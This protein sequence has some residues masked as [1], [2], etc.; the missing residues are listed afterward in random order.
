M[1]QCPKCMREFKNDN[2]DHFCSEKPKTIEEYILA[3]PENVQPILFEVR[4]TLRGA[5]PD[6]EERI[7]W[8]MPTFWKKQNIIHFAAFKNHMGLY[9]GPDAIVHFA[10]CL[11]DY[12]SSKGAIQ[13]PYNKPFPMELIVDIAKWCY[14]TGNHH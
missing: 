13:F 4:D 1:W 2:Q 8:S 5:L 14:K 12:K 6:V 10:D 7:S 11:T 3:Q 9:P